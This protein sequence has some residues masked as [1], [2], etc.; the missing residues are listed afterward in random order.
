MKQCI[1]F[2]ST[3]LALIITSCKSPVEN[4]NNSSPLV[5]YPFFMYEFE[6]LKY[7]NP[8]Y[9]NNVLINEYEGKLNWI[10][11]GAAHIKLR[12][13]VGK[14]PYV[15]LGDGYYLTNWY[16]ARPFYNSGTYI[17]PCLINKTWDELKLN[18]T[19]Y[20]IEPMEDVEIIMRHPASE[21]YYIDYPELDA[22]FGTKLADMFPEK[23]ASS[24]ETSADILSFGGITD[25][26]FME[27]KYGEGAFHECIDACTEVGE[28]Y[29]ENIKQL[30]KSGELFKIAKKVSNPNGSN[31][32]LPW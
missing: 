29:I 21:L 7:D 4:N 23:F 11:S 27:R 13:M 30:Y 20:G 1:I 10:W 15:E 28:H 6:I 9:I 26:V 2:L 22:Y 19:L 17:Y 3:I 5:P 18:D 24:I 16:V 25:S 12:S 8:E 32:Y 31:E 14:N